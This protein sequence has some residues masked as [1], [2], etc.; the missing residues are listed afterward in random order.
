MWVTDDQGHKILSQEPDNVLADGHSKYLAWFASCRS[1]LE[2][3]Y[4]EQADIKSY[5]P[6]TYPTATWLVDAFPAP[7][8]T[9]VHNEIGRAISLIELQAVIDNQ[10]DTKS[11]GRSGLRI[12]LLQY[13]DES[14][15]KALLRIL[16]LCL[17]MGKVPQN[18]KKILMVPIPKVE[19][20]SSLDDTQTIPKVEHPSSL[21]DTR[22]IALMEVALKLLT[23]IIGQGTLKAWLDHDLLEKSQYAFLPVLALLTHFK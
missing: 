18:W 6:T 15:L 21:D 19:H 2:A 1:A 5:N 16:S 4:I 11:A 20:P 23:K 10:P 3:L 7:D 12:G 13:L 9:T 17:L 8:Q 14:V 22:P